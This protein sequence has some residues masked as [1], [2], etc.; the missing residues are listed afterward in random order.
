MSTIAF[1]SPFAETGCSSS[2]LMSAYATA[3]QYRARVLLVNTGPANYGVESG[4]FQDE[5]SSADVLYSFEENGWDAVERLFISGSLNKHNLK[6]YTKP[7]LKEQLDLLTGSVYRKERSVSEKEELLKKLLETAN[8]CY[9]L[10]LLDA[11]QSHV[12]SQLIVQQAD[13][14]VVVLN[15]N[16][17]HLEHFFEEILPEQITERKLHVLINKYDSHSRATLSNIKRGFRYKGSLSAVPYTTG[18]L[19]AINRRDV[20]RYLQLESLTEKKQVQKGS[21]ASAMAELARLIMDGTGMRTVLKRLE[22]GA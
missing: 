10:V 21:F 1:W 19:D 22:R 5:K 14:V 12:D 16:M 20:A 8:Q 7:L 2:A 13:V 15:Q 6:D 4:I 3:F 17:R 11:G 18:Y 9:D